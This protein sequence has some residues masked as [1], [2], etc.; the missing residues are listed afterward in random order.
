[1][2]SEKLCSSDYQ[3][4]YHLG[5][6]WIR[7]LLSFTRDG[8]RGRFETATRLDSRSSAVLSTFGRCGPASVL[9]PVRKTIG[10]SQRQ[11]QMDHTNL[12]EALSR[13]RELRRECRRT[14][15]Q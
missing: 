8:N 14:D 6:L 11:S 12:Q 15:P 3:H 5:I 9:V 10:L 2:A 1:M 7:S 13:H 4:F